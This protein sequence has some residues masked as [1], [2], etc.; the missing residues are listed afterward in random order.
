MAAFL[1]R[2][3]FAF[4]TWFTILFRNRIPDPVAAALGTSP[5]RA[6]TPRPTP[7]P[8]RTTPVE[9]T[10]TEMLALLQRDGRLVDFLMED[11]AAYADAQVGAAVREVHTGCRQALLRHVTLT[12]VIEAQEGG[13]VTVDVG[14][15]AARVKVIGNVTGHPPFTGVLRHR[16]WSAARVELPTLPASGRSIV[17]PAEVELS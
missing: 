4:W 6:H 8:A 13:R 11:I 17:A 2:V 1:T 10:A 12:P 14:T 16:G 3:K 9:P 5:A 15:D 7:T